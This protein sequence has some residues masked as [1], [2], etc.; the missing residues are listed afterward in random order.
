[1]RTQEFSVLSQAWQGGE[2]WF[3]L[4]PW[5]GRAVAECTWC[6]SS[7]AV[8]ARSELPRPASP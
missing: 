2:E 3:V 4:E 6:C 1:M 5:L 8:M 7:A